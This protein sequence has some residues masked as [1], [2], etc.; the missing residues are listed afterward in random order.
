M[1]QRARH[2]GLRWSRQEVS[3]QT[4]PRTN[5]SSLCIHPRT[6]THIHSHTLTRASREHDTNHITNFTPSFRYSTDANLAGLSHEAEDLESIQ[7]PMLIVEPEMGCWPQDAPVPPV[8][9]CTGFCCLLHISDILHTTFRPAFTLISS[10][11]ALQRSY[12]LF[13]AV[14]QFLSLLRTR[15]R[16]AP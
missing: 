1:A 11:C 5:Y 15:S 12:P 2:R 10:C 6:S 7:T 4:R 3:S 16:S 13:C 14:L 9:A 8:F